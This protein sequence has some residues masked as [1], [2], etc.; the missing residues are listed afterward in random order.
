MEYKFI[1]DPI[2]KKQYETKGYK[3]QKIINIYSNILVGGKTN[4]YVGYFFDKSEIGFFISSIHSRNILSISIWFF[5]KF[6]H[7]P[8]LK[9]SPPVPRH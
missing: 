2:T 1:I 3:G 8:S 9:L 4:N 6:L 5:I 7:F